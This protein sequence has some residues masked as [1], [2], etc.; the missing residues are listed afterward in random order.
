M[1]VK[2][3]REKQMELSVNITIWVWLTS[4]RWS[5]HKVSGGGASSA[6]RHR[7]CYTWTT[8][9]SPAQCSVVPPQQRRSAHSWRGRQVSRTCCHVSTYINLVTCT[10]CHLSTYTDLVTYTCCHAST[11]TDLV[12]CTCCHMSAD[13][14]LVTSAAWELCSAMCTDVAWWCSSKKKAKAWYLI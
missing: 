14:D 3:E 5:G 8:D 10:C 12:T 13:T 6:T 2:T 11:Y 1:A 4:H 9:W 7:R